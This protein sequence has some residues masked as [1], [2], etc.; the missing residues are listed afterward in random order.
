MPE[1]VGYGPQFTASVGKLLNYIGSHAYGYSGIIEVDQTSPEFF[2]FTSA[3]SYFVGEIQFNY[4]DTSGDD[5]MRYEVKFNGKLV[6]S[7]IVS[8]S[9]IYTSP[10]NVIPLLIP[11]YTK[12]EV[13]GYNISSTSGRTNAA[14]IVGRIYGKVD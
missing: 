2:S 3:G 11:P 4:Y 6:Q 5:D 1:G 12:V 14:S 13:T 10:D 9:Y 7:Y 8:H